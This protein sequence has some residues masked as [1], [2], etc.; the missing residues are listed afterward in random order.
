MP[1]VW[2]KRV[3]FCRVDRPVPTQ[4]VPRL[5][6]WG[7]LL[8]ITLTGCIGPR[9]LELTRLR[10][11]QAV[12]ETTEQQWLRNIVRL[13]YGDLPSFMDVAA[14]TSQFELSSRGSFTGGKQRDSANNSY[15]GDMALQFRDAPTLSYT[16]RD[17]TELTRAMVAPVGITALGLIANNGWSFDDVFRLMVA[18]VNG[19]ENAPG[20]EQLIPESAPPPSL[21]GEMTRLA[22]QLRRDRVVSLAAFDLPRPV[23]SPI[24]AT[25]V[26]GSDLVQAASNKLEYRATEK[27]DELVLTRSEPGYRL[28]L[29]PAAQGRPEADAF[30]QLLRLAPRR[31]EYSVR[32]VEVPGGLELL[33]LPDA[34][35]SIDVRTRTLL[36]ML[37]FLSKGVEVP[38]KHIC[39]GLA[40]QTVGPDGFVFDW[41]AVTQGLFHVC[42]QK[43]RPNDSA[44]AIEYQGY[45]YY[46]AASDKRSKST[47][48]M[49]Q[50]LFNLQ[51]SEPK[52]GGPLL[53]LP[54]GL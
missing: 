38:E 33:P 12:H 15:F 6:P 49:I 20:A 25:R 30:R 27:A 21:F 32:R 52:K 40:A 43:K 13:R 3:G 51:L 17:P 44:V 9:S 14:I 39:Q 8:A 50:A 29:S 37:T 35:D 22:G 2:D 41:T 18:N 4:R 26:D 5:V 46:I 16:P 48:A 1:G 34:L 53:T 31:L 28:T 24:V 11:D 23:S 7:V 19:L 42:A 36:D 10:Y 45:W 47:L 54:V